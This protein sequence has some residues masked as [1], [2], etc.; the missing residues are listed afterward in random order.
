MPAAVMPGKR[1]F[2]KVPQL[3][4]RVGV[5]IVR[6]DA[7]HR[8][9]CIDD[10][11]QIPAVVVTLPTMLFHGIFDISEQYPNLSPL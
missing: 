11:H 1:D 7:G 10:W 4:K 9:I 5:V 6:H 8:M 2:G 3:W